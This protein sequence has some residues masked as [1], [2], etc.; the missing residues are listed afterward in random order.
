MEE[1]KGFQPSRSAAQQVRI[2]PEIIWLRFVHFKCHLLFPNPEQPSTGGKLPEQI[3]H[4]YICIST[5]P[6]RNLMGNL[7]LLL[8]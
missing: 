8:Q 6:F 7:L 5:W 4:F 3:L 2:L 1:A